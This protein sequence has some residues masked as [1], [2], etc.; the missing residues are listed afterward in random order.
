MLPLYHQIIHEYPIIL[1]ILR[2]K[3]KILTRDFKPAKP[4]PAPVFHICKQ[5][6]IECCNVVVVGDHR[7]DIECGKSAGTGIEI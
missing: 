4:D 5:W 3:I 1:I 6:K 7:H 2:V